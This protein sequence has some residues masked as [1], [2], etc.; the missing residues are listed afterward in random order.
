MSR[1]LSR[2]LGALLAGWTLAASAQA[3]SAPRQWLDRLAPAL[4]YLD[5]VWESAEGDLNNDGLP[6]LAMVITGSRD[7]QAPREERLVVLTGQP[8]GGYRLLSVSG[9][10]CHPSKF[11]NLEIRR[12]SLYVTM[13]ETA[14]A[15]RMGSFTRHYRY[16]AR[17]QDMELIGEDSH[18]EDQQGHF[19]H[20]SANYLTGQ[21]IETTRERGRTRTRSSRIAAPAHPALQGQACLP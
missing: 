17:L 14:D 21:A 11:Y 8:G 20:T 12:Q 2:T 18:S 10:F 3:P 16:N 1:H 13:V 5:F 6:D 9:E 7:D 19:A 4:A 15:S